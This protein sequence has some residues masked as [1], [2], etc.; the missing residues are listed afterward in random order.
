[1]RDYADNPY[2]GVSTYI[3]HYDGIIR[4]NAI[5]GDIDFYD[6]GVELAQ[7][8]GARVLHNSVV[9]S[10]DA[11]GFFSSIDYRFPST[12]VEIRNNLV[13]RITRRGDANGTVENNLEAAALDLFVDPAA[14]D[15]H[16][17]PSA[18]A[19]IDQGV[20]TSDAG[21]DIDGETRDNGTPDLG[22]D[23]R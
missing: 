23:E 5:F 9:S 1:V 10:S 4:G 14:G 18:A 12:D 13:R 16:L 20:V 6:T 11:S 17:R 19:A 8:R 21:L 2:P 3:G 15:L 7:A 22:A